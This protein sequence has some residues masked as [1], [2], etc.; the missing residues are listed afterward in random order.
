MAGL[1]EF[2]GGK[3]EST[4]S[5]AFALE[6]EIIEELDVSIEVGKHFMTTSFEYPD[7]AI[8]LVSYLCTSHQIIT[9][10]HVHQ[11]VLYVPIGELC[12]YFFAPADIPI[13][14]KLVLKSTTLHP[15]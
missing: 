11:G 3:V 12:A 10:S 2:P 9:H 8:T 7:F 6:R 1:W 14:E 4:E 15:L 5:D 13:V